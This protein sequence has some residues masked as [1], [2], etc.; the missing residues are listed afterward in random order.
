MQ[1]FTIGE[2]IT[3]EGTFK[4]LY[5]NLVDPSVVQFKYAVSNA[6]GGLLG[7]TTTLT[8]TGSS[9]PAVGSVYRISKGVYQAQIDPTGFPGYWTCEWLSTGT[10]QTVK[11]F[12]LLVANRSL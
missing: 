12:N 3:P 7:P 1:I 4:D 5:G 8:Y 10:G 6:L 2:I 9:T 11:S